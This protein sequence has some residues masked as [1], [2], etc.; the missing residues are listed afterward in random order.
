MPLRVTWEWINPRSDNTVRKLSETSQ[1]LPPWLT[2]NLGWF[3]A[4]HHAHVTHLP[5][6]TVCFHFLCSRHLLRHPIQVLT[7]NYD[8]Q[9]SCGSSGSRAQVAIDHNEA[10][11]QVISVSNYFIW[12]IKLIHPIFCFPEPWQLTLLRPAHKAPTLGEPNNV[13]GDM[14]V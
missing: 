1:N 10:I 13:Q 3:L 12:I 2:R 8:S 7:D 5:L 9:I 4:Y 14:A 11:I 6:W